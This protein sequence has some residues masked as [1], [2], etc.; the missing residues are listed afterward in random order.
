MRSMFDG[1]AVAEAMLP[2]SSNLVS[3]SML[4]ECPR[5]IR[6]G[7]FSVSVAVSEAGAG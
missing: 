1:D 3:C 5:S 7:A 6:S 2:M 4:D